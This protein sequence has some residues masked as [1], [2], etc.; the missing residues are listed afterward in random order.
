MT[1]DLIVV[2]S[3]TN[4][5]DFNSEFLYHNIVFCLQSSNLYPFLS[6]VCLF[7]SEWLYVMEKS[8]SVLILDF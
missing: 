8:L 3:V 6:T 7:V 4:R 2:C 5:V 1:I